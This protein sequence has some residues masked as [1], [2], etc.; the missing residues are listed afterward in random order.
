MTRSR[1]T[2]RA[3][4][5]SAVARLDYRKAEAELRAALNDAERSHV[6]DQELTEILRELVSVQL[7][8]YE[9]AGSIEPFARRLLDLQERITGPEAAEFILA[10]HLL[11]QTATKLKRFQEAETLLRR[12]VALREKLSGPNAPELA[13]D[14]HALGV[15]LWGNKRFAEAEAVFRRA[16]DI[17]G[18]N[19]EDAS[20]IGLDAVRIAWR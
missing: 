5:R 9:S 20:T 8:G 18:N 14:L 2:H 7:R 3:A 16:V 19:P 6:G 17:I 10:L 13:G 1:E 12:A 15:R 4:A 11:A